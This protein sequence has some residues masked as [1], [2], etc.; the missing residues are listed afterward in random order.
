MAAWRIV[1]DMLRKKRKIRKTTRKLGGAMEGFLHT[2][3]EVS[4]AQAVADA[5]P[6]RR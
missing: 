6:S 5:G 2:I 4:E 3:T 1:E